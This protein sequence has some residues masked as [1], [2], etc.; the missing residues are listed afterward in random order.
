MGTT[1]YK[2]HLSISNAYYLKFTRIIQYFLTN[3]QIESTNIHFVIIFHNEVLFNK[4]NNI[5]TKN[6]IFL[7]K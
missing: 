4:Y 3:I 5:I 2:F 6:H 1:K 7:Y